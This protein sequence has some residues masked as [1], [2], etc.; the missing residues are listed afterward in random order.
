[1]VDIDRNAVNFEPLTDETGTANTAK[2]GSAK[3]AG[4]GKKE[5]QGPWLK[6]GGSG[7]KGPSN[8]FAK[9]KTTSGKFGQKK[10][11][12]AQGKGNNSKIR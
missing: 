6:S 7:K 5:Q 12:K 1:M 2:P 11:G 8:K 3:R 9:S 4:F 10:S